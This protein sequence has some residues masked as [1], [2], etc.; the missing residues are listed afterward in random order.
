MSFAKNR[1]K[2]RVL[3]AL[4]REWLTPPTI[5]ATVGFSPIRAMYSYLLRLH[6]W[7]LLERRRDTRGL[8]LY[9]ISKRGLKRLEWLRENVV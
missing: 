8:I 7:G 4:Q 5:A 6:R 9:R 2:I 1:L 3:D